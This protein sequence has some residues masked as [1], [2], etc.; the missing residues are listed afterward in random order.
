M[1]LF[2]YL[3]R[4]LLSKRSLKH[5]HFYTLNG[6][7]RKEKKVTFYDKKHFFLRKQ[8]HIYRHLWVVIYHFW[9]DGAFIF[10]RIVVGM[11]FV[12]KCGK[13]TNTQKATAAI[14]WKW[15]S[16]LFSVKARYGRFCARLIHT[17]PP[18]ILYY[19]N[20]ISQISC[21]NAHP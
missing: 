7:S 10:N 14:Q 17:L 4:S 8:L 1:F 6:G 2:K 20:W 13:C 21:S 5:S 15:K 16:R 9:S 3:G 11:Y 12:F 18:P 19:E